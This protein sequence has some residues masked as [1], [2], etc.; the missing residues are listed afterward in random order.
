MN[1]NFER[2]FNSIPMNYPIGLVYLNG[3]AV[4]VARFSHLNS[5]TGL[6]FFV[7]VDG[8]MTALDINKIDGLGFGE[9]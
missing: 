8:V 5:E 2:F 4:E 6:A 9:A 7:D 1:G 3:M